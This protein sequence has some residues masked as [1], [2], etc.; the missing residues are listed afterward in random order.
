M[1]QQQVVQ[2]VV[3][4]NVSCAPASQALRRLRVM[5]VPPSYTLL[6]VGLRKEISSPRHVSPSSWVEKG[7]R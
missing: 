4:D 5:G 7:G 1:F 6:L 3:E 2:L